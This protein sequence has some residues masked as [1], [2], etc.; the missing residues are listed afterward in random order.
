MD[1]ATGKNHFFLNCAMSSIMNIRT[2]MGVWHHVQTN[3]L[4]FKCE[5]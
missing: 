1:E 3:A 4:M 2:K 5:H